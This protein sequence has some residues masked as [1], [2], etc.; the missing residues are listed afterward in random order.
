[1]F[2]ALRTSL[3]TKSTPGLS[4]ALSDWLS[5]ELAAGDQLRTIPA[6][7]VARM[8]VDLALPEVDSLGKDTL[9]RIRRDV[10]SDWVVV[11]SYAS[12]RGTSGGDVR[13]D[14]RLQDAA[15]GETI[16]TLSEAGSE[17]DLFKLISNAG[18]HLRAKLD[19]HSITP[20]QQA[21]VAV[22]LPSNR[23]AARF[24]AEG[25]DKLRNF[26]ALAA[27]KLLLKAI[28][29]E[30]NDALL[31][32]ALAS[33]WLKLGHDANAMAEAKKAVE[34]SSS[35]PWTERSL[36]LARQSEVSNRW[37]KAIET[38]RLLFEFYPDR[39]DYGLALVHAQVKAGK[40]TAAGETVFAL[41][42]LHPSL[43]DESS[44][45]LAEADAADSQGDLKK[46]LDLANKGAEKA[47]LMGA[48][49]LLAHALTM[50][51]D[52]L[53]GLGRLSEAAEAVNESTRLFA[54]IGDRDAL[55][56]TQAMG[57]HLLE[58]QGD[59]LAASKTY[60][61]SLL[62][63][64]SIGDREGIARELNNIAVERK[65]LGGSK[66]GTEEL[67]RSADRLV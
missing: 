4:T 33:A 9:Q 64:R 36:I 52:E 66:G 19:I 53:R 8:K 41:R 54:T 26:D 61:A 42:R 20:E 29:L 28:A 21:E 7:D 40:G 45:D 46:A 57:A 47:R 14:I 18:E 25:M 31:H 15:T 67:S 38:Y 34:L 2:L 10:G 16:A 24:Y 30:P 49:V 35:L 39:I 48:S 17:S 27:Q 58:F 1:M 5:A 3:A 65:Q 43:G 60:E 13:V 6:E 37:E 62:T 32:S 63:F 50:R 23:G 56:R 59:Y 44:I 51:A 12:L 22:T 55:A 11:G